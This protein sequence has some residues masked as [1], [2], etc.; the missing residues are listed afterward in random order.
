MLNSIVEIN[1]KWGKWKHG[2]CSEPCGT[3]TRTNTRK[4]VVTEAN[5]GYCTGQPTEIEECNTKPCP[6]ILSL[7]HI[8][9]T[10][11]AWK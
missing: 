4:K 6:G 10:R 11:V 1:C 5:G 3:G 7:V 9:I 2:K 8:L